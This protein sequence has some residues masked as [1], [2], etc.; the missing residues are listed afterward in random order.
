LLLQQKN[1]AKKKKKIDL[2]VDSSEYIKETVCLTIQV[3]RRSL[4]YCAI[5]Q[6]KVTELYVYDI[7]CIIR[8]FVYF[9]LLCD[10]LRN[11]NFLPFI[12]LGSFVRISSVPSE[13][14]GEKRRKNTAKRKVTS[15][16]KH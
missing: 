4:I 8:R 11:L 14:P 3:F 6:M 1:K 2:A 10:Y 13:P 12:S 7:M 5:T 15:A 16:G 9:T